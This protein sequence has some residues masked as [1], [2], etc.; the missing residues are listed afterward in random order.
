[1]SEAA[2]MLEASTDRLF[3]DRCTADVVRSA[4]RGE[5]P[6]DL[7]AG[8]QADELAL[9]AVPEA[10]GGT[11]ASLAEVAAI[12]RSVGRHAV[13]LPLIETVLANQL[14]ARSG[15]APL[16]GPA[17][18]SVAVDGP[19]LRLQRAGDAWRL[20]GEVP[21]VPWG[22]QVRSV[23][24]VAQ[25]DDGDE[26]VL[27]VAPSDARITEGRSVA[28]EPRVHLAFEGV[29]VD[30][31]AVRA[32]RGRDHGQA[33]ATA[34]A[35]VRS[36]QMVGAMRWLL[37]ATLRYAGERTQF[38]RPIG[39]FQ[40]V[41]HLIAEMAEHVSAAATAADAAM[42][43]SEAGWADRVGMAKAR[44]GEAAGTVADAAH[45]VHGAM[46]YTQEYPLHLRTRR[47]WCWREEF[48]AERHWRV[49]IGRAL[50]AAGGESF[51]AQLTR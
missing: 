30:D 1:M 41:Q 14:L 46:G 33:L 17:S 19:A 8:V 45:Q 28:F 25:G 9:C 50:A 31:R 26:V 43:G 35:L 29:R 48:G 23:V 40:S 42:L 36:H 15:H 16:T 47:L 34:G 2:R 49:R 11:G 37:D 12:A 21:L 44:I 51:W 20:S 22:A 32:G 3:G 5:W 6:A 27:A 38:G 39:G 7:W 18:V 4:E 24:V 13:P 10:L